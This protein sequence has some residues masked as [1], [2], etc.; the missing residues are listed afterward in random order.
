[1]FETTEDA[2]I[3]GNLLTNFGAG[4]DFDPEGDPLVLVALA[5][6]PVEAGAQPSIP[7]PSGAVV[8]IAS[9]GAFTYSPG[10]GFNGLSEGETA[11]DSFVYRITD[12]NGGVSEAL[13]TFLVSGVND[14]PNA[15]DDAFLVEE[16]AL[17]T[18]SLLADNGAGADVDAEGDEL[19]LTALNGIAVQAGQEISLGS[20]AV[21]TANPDG[22][23]TY[24]QGAAFDALGAGAAGEDSFSYTIS[25]GVSETSASAMISILGVNDA[26]V[27]R[28]DAF[29]VLEG[30]EASGDLLADNG[31]GADSDPDANDGALTISALD[32]L[33]ELTRTLASGASVSL[34]AEGALLYRT[35]GAFDALA[36][37]ETATDSFTYTLS[38]GAASDVATVTLTIAGVNDAPVAQLDAFATDE[39]TRITG[40][41]LFE[42]NGSGADFDV[43]AD[44][45]RLTAIDGAEI[46]AGDAITLASGAIVEISANGAIS[47]DPNGAFAQLEDGETAVDRFTYQ[48]ADAFDAR[49]EAEVEVEIAG[50]SG[51]LFG[52]LASDILEGGAEG[53]EIQGLAGDDLISGFGGDDLIDAGQGADRARGGGGD[54]ALLGGEGDDTLF[55]ESGDDSLRG[56]DGADRLRGQR[57]DDMLF[58]DAGDD[59]LAGARDSD[60]LRGGG[61]DDTLLG[62]GGDDRLFGQAGVDNLNGGRG[63]DNLSGGSGNDRLRGGG[64]DDTLVGGGGDDTLIGGLGADTFQFDGNDGA[65]VLRGFQQGVDRIEIT[66]DGFGFSDLTLTQVGSNVAISFGSTSVLAVAQAVGT[67]AEDDFIF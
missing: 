26:P 39:D 58:G 44:D 66:S 64:G 8:T 20:G 19:A 60:L 59:V 12:Q 46:E 61:G 55:G 52:T 21:V 51:V 47:Y 45:L 15:V 38:D 22:T 41:F 23:F 54:D 5:G 16:N 4:E 24:V 62:G 33:S 30:G 40:L 29:D 32:G 9:D 48:I 65:D 10:D 63:E 18:G 28:N 50:L 37:G 67:F 43:D 6:V 25:D 27:A 35:N 36:E 53:D 2:P 56:G 7:L 14:A 42:D 34:T 57:G 1:M 31:A 3:V 49:A 13:A 17:L 11:E